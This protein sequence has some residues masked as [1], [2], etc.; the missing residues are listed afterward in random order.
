[1]IQKLIKKCVHLIRKKCLSGPRINPFW[2]G[3]DLIY[4]V[5]S[6]LVPVE[7]VGRKSGLHKAIYFPVA[8]NIC[9]CK[10][11]QKKSRVL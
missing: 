10:Q 9:R 5:G 3:I 6:E 1:M 2:C 7:G 11:Q 4:A 8:K